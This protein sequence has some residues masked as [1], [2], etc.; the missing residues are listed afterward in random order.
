M[1]MRCVVIKFVKSKDK[2]Q[3]VEAAQETLQGINDI[4]EG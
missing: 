3:N 1:K 2:E 4:S